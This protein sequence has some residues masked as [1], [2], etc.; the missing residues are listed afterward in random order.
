MKLAT[1]ITSA[2][3]GTALLVTSITI[4]AESKIDKIMKD[5]MKGETSLF[6]KVSLGKGTDEDTQKLLDYVKQLAAEKPSKGSE[7]SWKEKTEALIKATEDVAAKKPDSLKA[8]QKAGNCKACHTE[9]KE[10]K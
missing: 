1:I 7:A 4:A 10:K 8:L 9:H 5:S 2:V 6:K 3:A